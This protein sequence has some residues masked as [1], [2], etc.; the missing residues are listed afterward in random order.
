ME[1]NWLRA[2]TRQCHYLEPETGEPDKI[3]NMQPASTMWPGA[4]GK[5]LVTAALDHNIRLWNVAQGRWCGCSRA[6]GR[7]VSVAYSPTVSGWLGQF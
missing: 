6:C 1:N 4:D 2:G 5:E 3:S 7:V